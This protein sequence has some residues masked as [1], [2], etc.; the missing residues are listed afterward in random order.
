MVD[1]TPQKNSVE[2]SGCDQEKV[3]SYLKNIKQE[4]N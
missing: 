1:K 4:M 3:G 2:A